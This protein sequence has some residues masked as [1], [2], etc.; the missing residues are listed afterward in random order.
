LRYLLDTN[1]CIGILKGRSASVIDR[2]VAL[3]AA[4]IALPTIV[5]AEL[6]FGAAKSRSP[7]RSRAAQD[8]LTSRFAHLPFDERC[9]DEYARIRAQLERAG[10]PIGPYDL[11]IAATACA[12]GL[13]LVTHNVGEFGR[14][15][16]LRVEDWER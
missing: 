1:V 14:V 12:F 13:T 8:A 15:A 11:I 9:A 10:T 7:E 6:W 2:L 16:G 5:L 4:E 3:D